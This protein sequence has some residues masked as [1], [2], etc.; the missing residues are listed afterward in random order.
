MSTNPTSEST[1]SGRSIRRFITKSLAADLVLRTEKTIENW[2]GHG[3][4]TGY[5][6]KPG[7]PILIDRLELEDALRKNPKMRD[8]RKVFGKDARIVPMPLGG[9][10]A[11]S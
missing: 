2:L 6:E 4:I 7:G 8:G 10:G 11:D 5:R 9:N 1:G 3:Y